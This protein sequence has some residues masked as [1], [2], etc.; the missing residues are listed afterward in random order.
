MLDD[1]PL[2]TVTDATFAEGTPGLLLS[3]KGRLSLPADNF[4]A[5]V[6]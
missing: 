6:E 3:S 4:S 5:T 1:V 2:L